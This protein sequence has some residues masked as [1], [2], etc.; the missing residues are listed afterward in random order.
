MP[1]RYK[2]SG[3]ESMVAILLG[4]AACGGQVATD[5]GGSGIGGSAAWA[6]GGSATG[7]GATGGRIGTAGSSAVGGGGQGGQDWTACGP[8]D[9]CV[10][11]PTG[12]CGPGCEP[13]PLSSYTAINS[14]Y[15][16]E[17]RQSIPPVPCIVLIGGCPVLT[18]DQLGTPNYYATCEQGHCQVVDLRTS[19]LSTC[20][21]SSDCYI[22]SGTTCCGCGNTDWVAASTKAN[23]E[24]LFCAPAAACTADCTVTP[25]CLSA[26]CNVSGHCALS[27]Y[28]I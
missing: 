14:T 11:E 17:Y 10:L 5:S 24:Q 2:M 3:L 22:R 7:P 13:V 18:P 1:Q 9:T 28:C 20:L 23:V 4:V 6:V 15:V 25:S 8:T 19:P 26:F 12:P 21:S 16:T 27:Y